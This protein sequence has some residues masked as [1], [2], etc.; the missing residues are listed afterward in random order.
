MK[1]NEV[2]LR[3]RAGLPVAR[4]VQQFPITSFASA[5]QLDVTRDSVLDP[6]PT[7]RRS[8]FQ[9]DRCPGRKPSAVEGV[10]GASA[11]ASQ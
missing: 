5:Y 8:D 7:H 1:L 6:E 3:L 2:L 11:Q 4:A 10:T 9:L